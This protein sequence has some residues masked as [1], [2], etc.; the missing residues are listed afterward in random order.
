MGEISESGDIFTKTTGLGP[1]IGRIIARKEINQAET[2]ILLHWSLIFQ[3]AGKNSFP[4]PG[5]IH[6]KLAL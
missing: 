6:L 3:S 4:F 1:C 2:K 5:K